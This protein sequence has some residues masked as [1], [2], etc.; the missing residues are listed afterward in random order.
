M[1]LV[2]YRAADLATLHW[3]FE[4]IGSIVDVGPR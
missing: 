1:M 3:E 4:K 2:Y